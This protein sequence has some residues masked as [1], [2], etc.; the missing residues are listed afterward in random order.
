V[1][2]VWQS[3]NDGTLL[4]TKGAEVFITDPALRDVV[5][6]RNAATFAQLYLDQATPTNYGTAI[7]E[8]VAG[9]VAGALTPEQVTQAM[10]DAAAAAA[11]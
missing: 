7:N 3:F 8:A 10:T 6:Q 4:P 2:S 1:A 9:L 11:G 5:T